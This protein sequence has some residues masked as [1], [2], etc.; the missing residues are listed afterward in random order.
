MVDRGSRS[1]VWCMMNG[2]GWSAVSLVLSTCWGLLSPA[3]PAQSQEMLP[4]AQYRAIR[5]QASGE[6]PLAD[7]K[8]I[9]R[10]SGFSPSVGAD[11]VADYLAGEAKTIGLEHI[12]V[13]HY[14]SDG[15]S[16]YWAFHR[17]P[18]WEGHKGE[19][20]LVA[21]DRELIA[22]FKAVRSFLGRY[23]R[24]SSATA[25]LVDVG[26]GDKAQDYQGRSVEGKIVLVGGSASAAMRLAV[27]ERKALGVV[28]YRTE[29][30]GD[31]PDQIGMVQ[32]VP[33]IGPHGEAPTFA[34]SI[35]NRTAQALKDRLAAGQ[36][37]SVHADVEADSGP[38][39]YP[40]VRA[41]IPG[42][43]PALPAVLVYA[44]DNSRNT[45]GANN[46]TGVGCTLEVA[47]LLHQLIAAGTL[48]QPRR[49]LRFMWGAEHYGITQHFHEHPDDLANILAM[50]NIDMIGYN[51]QTSRAV[52]H[53]Y[54]SPY[55]NPSFIDDIVQ[56]FVEKV[57]R[58]NTISIRSFD[59]TA[60]NPSEGFA[61]PIF[62]PTGSRQQF[63]YNTEGFWGPSD[64]EDAQALGVRAVLLNDFPDVFLSTQDDSPAAVDPTQM[65]RGVV[66]SAAAAYFL[67]SAASG[68]TPEL[69]LN[70][71]TKAT[72][73]LVDDEIKASGYL[74]SAKDE[75][76]PQA[77]RDATNVI[78]EAVARET[79][80]LNSLSL[81]VGS[82]GFREQ[83]RPFLA[84]V[85]A[86]AQGAS[87]RISALATA[88]AAQLHVASTALPGGA[89]DGQ[90]SHVVPVRTEAVRGPVNFFRPEYGRWWLIEK[91]GD[92]HFEKQVPLSRRGFYMTYEALNFADGKRS[93][94]EIRDALS[95]EYEPVP[96]SEVAQYFQFMEK[97]GVVH[98]L[99]AKSK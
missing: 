3:L 95:A 15:T 44:H 78:K 47:R 28:S 45:G 7:F 66:L 9:I 16:F 82:Q 30:A 64:H 39:Q 83:E 31:F 10:F 75:D 89:G 42:K 4:P 13:E 70:A 43:D 18:Y 19:L 34:F 21:P 54:R 63:Q 51:Q 73:R 8:K 85:T 68:D 69:L 81:L 29:F 52:F 35:S 62:A 79:T 92:E 20:W 86:V 11:E 50:I 46:L 40:E 90:Y 57:G 97:F 77:Y 6:R 94:A 87:R 98:E 53:L 65:R 93:V 24:T 5:D 38:G 48:P 72:K 25:E 91:T 12:A 22:D 60:V 74:E 67:G 26:S 88:R 84:D 56:S 27:W 1:R 71:E 58:E 32:V 61:D 96:V 17:E 49:T 41:E 2:S 23:S 55:S 14:S 37:L 59:V 80:S 33:W 36:K 99:G 76:L